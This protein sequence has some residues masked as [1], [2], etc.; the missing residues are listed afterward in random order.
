MRLFAALVLSGSLVLAQPP[1]KVGVTQRSFVPTRS[2]VWRGAKTHA[3]ATTIWYPA[4]PSSL[5]QPQSI[6]PPDVPLIDAGRAAPDAPAARGRYPL[7][8]LSH[9]T[10]GS[11]LTLGWLGTALAS[12]GYVVAGVNHPGNN[13]LEP[14]T[15]AGFSLWWERATDLSE[16]IDGMLADSEVR[17]HIDPQRI[18]AAG[19]SLG[20]YTMIEIAGGVSERSAF[21]EFCRSPK[22]DGL[23]KSPPEFPELLEH[24]NRLD[25]LAKDDP[26]IAESLHREKI[27]HRDP[28]VRAVFAIAPA[29]GPAFPP[30]TLKGIA[31]PVQI[32]AGSADD[33]VP[34]ASSARY[35]ASQI[36]GSQLHVFEGPVRHYEFLGTCTDL[37]KQRLPQLCTDDPKVNRASVER[38]TAAMAVRFFD[39]H[40]GKANR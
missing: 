33:N 14:Y 4:D 13:A 9:G 1:L 21:Q 23:C 8:V 7:V 3:L 39:Q 34:I 38:E 26:E 25:E 24:F 36:R 28:R 19:F 30:A 5:E 40:L 12:H 22:A 6:G 11:A 35:F 10:G 27:S 32:V 17:S 15:V 29:L 20:G 16:V 18:G 31:I 2:Y 37:G